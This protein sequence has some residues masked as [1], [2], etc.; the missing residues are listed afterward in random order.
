MALR[1]GYKVK[2]GG[3]IFTVVDVMDALKYAA[4]NGAHVINLSLGA[5]A[6]I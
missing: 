6:D 4:D 3:V 5:P 2:N 1:A